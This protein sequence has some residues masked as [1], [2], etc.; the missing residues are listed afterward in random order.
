[1]NTKDAAYLTVHNYLGG[2]PALAARMGTDANEL[3]RKLNPGSAHGISLDEA[4]VT[5]ALSGDRTAQ[6]KIAGPIRALS[7]TGNVRPVR[8]LVTR[9]Y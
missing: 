6:P 8:A 7:H 4:E 5:M 3:C 1:M 9:F 2:V